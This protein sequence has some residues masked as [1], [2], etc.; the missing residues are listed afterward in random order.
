MGCASRGHRTWGLR[1]GDPNLGPP[2]RCARAGGPRAGKMGHA[3]ADRGHGSAKHG[4]RDGAEGSR[5]SAARPKASPSRAVE[6]RPTTPVGH[7]GKPHPG[8]SEG[9]S[10]I[11]N[12][13]R[14]GCAP[15]GH[16][17]RD[18]H[19][20]GPNPGPPLKE[21]PDFPVQI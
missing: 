16:G 20:G 9:P 14:P 19:G 5:T 4:R 2:C 17:A 15:H 18:L 10:S 12:G 21:N 7:L 6:V 3:R 11:A 1:S 8:G 13:S